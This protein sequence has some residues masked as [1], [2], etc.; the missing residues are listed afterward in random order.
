MC[1]YYLVWMGNIGH[2]RF[3]HLLQIMLKFFSICMPSVLW[4]YWLGSR[5]GIRPVKTEWWNAGMVMCLGQ[6]ADLHMAQL[7]PLPLTVS[8]SSK[9]RL[10]LPF[11]C[12]LTQV[13]LGCK[14][15]VYVCVF[16]IFMHPINSFQFF[17]GC[18]LGDKKGT[19]LIRKNLWCES[20]RYCSRTVFFWRMAVNELTVCCCISDKWCTMVGC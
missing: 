14:T 5:K 13:V 19:W 12:S 8:C 7:M 15:V 20:L 18:C 17:W 9:S 2:Y 6:G 3:W 1:R 4:C 16:S 10:V 11:W